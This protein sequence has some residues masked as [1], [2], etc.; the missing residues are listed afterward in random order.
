MV[1]LEHDAYGE[2]VHLSGNEAPVVCDVLRERRR[3]LV[4]VAVQ[5]GGG[6]RAGD[7]CST[8]E[9]WE[10]AGEGGIGR[11]EIGEWIGRDIRVLD[12]PTRPS[13]PCRHTI[14][15]WADLV[16]CS[17]DLALTTG[18]AGTGTKATVLGRALTILFLLWHYLATIT[19]CWRELAATRHVPSPSWLPRTLIMKSALA[20]MTKRQMLLRPSR[21]P[22][23][24]PATTKTNP[25][26]TGVLEPL[27]CF[28]LRSAPHGSTDARNPTRPRAHL[29]PAGLPLA[30]RAHHVAP[31]QISDASHRA[32]T[33]SP[34]FR[35]PEHRAP[36]PTT[37]PR[38]QRSKGGV[39]ENH[40]PR[41]V[42][43]RRAPLNQQRPSPRGNKST[44][45]EPLLL[46]SRSS[47]ELNNHGER[48][49]VLGKYELGRMLGQ[50]TFAKVYY[51]RDLTASG[52]VSG[53]GTA[54]TTSTS[55]S[56]AIKVIDKARLR[57]TEGMM[58]QLRREISIMRLV[59]HPNVVG[60]R[61]V[62]A[63]RSR[64][65]VVMEYARGG[66][67]FA[68]VARGRLTED[69]ARRYFQQLVAAVGFCHRRGVAHRDL[70]P[71][72]LLLDE[73]GR[74]KVTDFGLAALPEQLRHDGLLHTQ[75]GTPAY[76]APEVLRKRGYDGARADL[77][78]CGVVLYVLL[79]GFL[80]FQHDNYAKMYQ[81][82]FKAEYQVPPWVSGD[83]RRLIGRLLVVDPAK[84][85]SVSEIMLTPWFRKGFVPPVLSPQALSP[86][87][88]Q[89]DLDGK[90]DDDAGALIED[91]DGNSSS[92]VSSPRSCNAFQ[93]IS[94]MSSGFDL[95]GLFESEQ[96]AATVFT[97]RAPANAVV[98]KLEA[99][100]H[101]LGFVVTRGKGSLNLRMEAKVEGTNGRLA[102]TAEVLEV[103]ADVAVVEFAHD[104]GDALDFNKFC[105]E[106]V[107]PG[108]ADIVWAWQGDSPPPVAGLCVRSGVQS[109]GD[110]KKGL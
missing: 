54:T 81:K 60:I 59:R 44:A 91:G 98:E 49:L 9:R 94:S 5:G 66:E 76:V 57:R 17:L 39:E 53:A 72:N 45:P 43:T 65:F 103:A 35:V 77:W 99:V 85:A 78:S 42:P 93:L 104:A 55:S 84:R 71:E 29:P 51:A 70:K 19:F 1:W 109:T 12:G 89:L 56:V 14:L 64:V 95:S 8:R 31:L 92:G 69:H 20:S 101:A 38:T 47:S 30:R 40:V 61:E 80:P 63:S 110:V 79:C 87:K 68:K 27:R 105:A 16:R 41:H 106:D 82:I 22:P 52:S 58:E 108:L 15:L 13:G 83:A 36:H 73:E 28:Q 2:H 37:A 18:H 90:E 74:L 107:R 75:C 62:L 25:R 34:Q 11:W 21:P 97:A 67:L 96:K 100:G 88:K 3:E 4:V 24:W 32:P 26:V 86:K 46:V 23:P 48:K 6:G 102:V 7:G 33:T 50:G 10:L